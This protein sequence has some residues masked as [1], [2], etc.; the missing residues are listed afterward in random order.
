VSSASCFDPRYEHE[1]HASL[2]QYLRDD[3][4]DPLAA[5]DDGDFLIEIHVQRSL[6][7]V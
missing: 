5:G 7:I 2:R 3:A 6:L 4:A 1:V